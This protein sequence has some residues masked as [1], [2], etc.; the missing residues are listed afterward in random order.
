MGRENEILARFR[1]WWKRERPE[2]NKSEFVLLFQRQVIP[3]EFQKNECFDKDKE[4]VQ[5]SY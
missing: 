1:W 5:I 4:Y 3:P 2:R